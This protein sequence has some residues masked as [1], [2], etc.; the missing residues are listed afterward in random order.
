MLKDYYDQSGYARRG[1]KFH[2]YIIVVTD[3]RGAIIAHE[4]SS[5]WLY[6]HLDN[7]KKLAAGNYLDQTCTRRPPI[8]PEPIHLISF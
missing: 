6:N 5:N 1:E 4:E 8:R 3:E 2:G 7:L